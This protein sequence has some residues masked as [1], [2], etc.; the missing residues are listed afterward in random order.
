MQYHEQ[1]ICLIEGERT[2]PL[3]IEVPATTGW[4]AYWLQWGPRGPGS[5]TAGE[6]GEEAGWQAWR[7]T[8]LRPARDGGGGSGGARGRRKWGWKEPWKPCMALS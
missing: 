6:S 3:G 8:G 1:R 2:S 7:S 5:E 4:Q